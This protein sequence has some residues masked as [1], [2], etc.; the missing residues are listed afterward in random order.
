[1]A[2]PGVEA[3]PMVGVAVQLHGQ[4][5]LQRLSLAPA[6]VDLGGESADAE[7]ESRQGGGVHRAR[8]RGRVR[9]VGDF[10]NA[11]AE[12]AQSYFSLGD[13]GEAGEGSEPGG[14]RRTLTDAFDDFSS[15][16]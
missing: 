2:L 4:A 9:D 16:R 11:G 6:D 15:Q 3:G 5:F 12:A 7:S 1:M 14:S 10:G 13:A 8:H